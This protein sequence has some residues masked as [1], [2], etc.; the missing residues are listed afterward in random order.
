MPFQSAQL[1]GQMLAECQR[2][3]ICNNRSDCRIKFKTYSTIYCQLRSHIPCFTTA[4]LVAYT[5][6]KSE[7]EN[8]CSVN[9]ISDFLRRI[10]YFC[11]EH[12]MQEDVYI[13]YT[14]LA[15]TLGLQVFL[16]CGQDDG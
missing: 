5:K 14:A 7:K 13:G 11:C 9:I 16:D 15:L 2:Q 4:I 6:H 12:Y 8:M 10:S 1:L 3:Y